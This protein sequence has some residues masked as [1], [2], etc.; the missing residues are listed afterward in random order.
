MAGPEDI[1]CSIVIPVHDRADLTAQCLAAIREN[2]GDVPYDVLVVDNGSTDS[3]TEFL[4]GL[5]SPFRSVRNEENLGFGRASNQG[6]DATSGQY[7]LFLNND[8]VPLPGWLGPMVECMESRPEVGIVGAKLLYPDSGL[9]QHAGVA[10]GEGHPF[11]VYKMLP[12]DLPEACE[13]RDCDAVTGACMLVR[14]SLF[15]EL[16]GFD[17]AYLNGL[18]DI[19]LC[20]RAR[21]L[22]YISRFSS[23][24]IVQ[25]Y[26]SMTEGRMDNNDRNHEVFKERWPASSRPCALSPGNFLALAGVRLLKID[27][28]GDKFVLFCRETFMKCD[29]C[30]WVIRPYHNRLRYYA[31]RLYYSLR[32]IKYWGQVRRTIREAERL[33][34]GRRGGPGE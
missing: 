27:E 13:D 6:A 30:P 2:T 31:A 22:G 8:T 33:A 9:M 34:A 21:E 18:E 7:I 5:R 17:V 14:R 32:Y 29:R 26:E 28:Q 11:H 19:D 3:T 1:L 15:E 16:G 12:A 23:R 10:V 25:H 20:M 4:A 24:S